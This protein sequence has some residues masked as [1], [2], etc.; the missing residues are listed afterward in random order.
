MWVGV[1]PWAG[2]PPER[3]GP[4]RQAYREI[5]GENVPLCSAGIGKAILAA[6]PESE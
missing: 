3:G 5:L 2:G 1:G 4:Y 6:M